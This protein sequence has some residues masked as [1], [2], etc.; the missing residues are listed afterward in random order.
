MKSI[1]ITGYGK[2]I[3]EN[4]FTNDQMA[5]IVD[6]SD[7]WISSR[8][9]IKT[10]AFAKNENTSDLCIKAGAKAIEQGNVNPLDIELVLVATMSPD[11][12]APSTAALVASA[13]G[14]VNAFAF[15]ISAA[16]SGFVFA[17]S[18]AQKYIVSGMYNK[19]LVIGGEVLSKT[20]N[21]E[22]RGTCVLFGD[23]AAA[24]CFSRTME[25]KFYDEILRTDGGKGEA[26]TCYS[27][28]NNN[29]ISGNVPDEKY[30]A[31]DGK[32]V[33]NF[34]T[35]EVPKNILSILHRNSIDE[36]SIKYF[37]PH[38]ANSRLIST[39]TKRIGFS[40][41]KTYVNI[42]RYGNTSAASIPIA[43]VELL[44]AGRIEEGDKI[45]LVGFGAGLTWG[46]I[47]F[48]Y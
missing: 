5:E 46:S 45:L 34:V 42:D 35:K 13:L 43:L 39:L 9:G 32:A 47:I 26:I 27:M 29:Y 8:T 37:I 7:D 40:K 3:P 31:M 1:K 41:D 28:K 36:S 19:V 2:Y 21:F 23:G 33:F 16:C 4:I 20:L 38:Q 44:E 15:D 14:C 10:R 24:F 18:T 17:M 22:D 30:M 6:T 11:Y 48:E 25:Y 12:I